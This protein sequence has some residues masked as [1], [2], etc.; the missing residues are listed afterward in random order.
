MRDRKEAPSQF[1][2]DVEF[3]LECFSKLGQVRAKSL[4]PEH[5]TA[6]QGTFDE[7]IYSL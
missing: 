3:A 2:L 4:F 7:M 6:W 5:Y 1:F